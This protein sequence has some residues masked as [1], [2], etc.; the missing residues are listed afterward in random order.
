MFIATAYWRGALNINQMRRFDAEED[1]V[2]YARKHG[3]CSMSRV[4]E[5]FKDK[6]PRL[7]RPS[8]KSRKP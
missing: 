1:A 5:V 2:S 8:R 4:Y 6:P 7:V 3:G